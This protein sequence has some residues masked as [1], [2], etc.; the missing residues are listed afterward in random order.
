VKEFIGQKDKINKD[1]QVPTGMPKEQLIA[2][3][4]STI[5]QLQAIK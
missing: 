3:L 1:K 5:T 4:Y 2:Q